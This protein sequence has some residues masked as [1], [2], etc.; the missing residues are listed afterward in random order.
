[1]QGKESGNVLQRWVNLMMRDLNFAGATDGF[2][3][4]PRT[5]D[6]RTRAEVLQL[7]ELILSGQAD[8]ELRDDEIEE[9]Q[10]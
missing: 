7:E 2:Q 4:D 8:Q 9:H 10:R 3:T 6:A 5:D 1:V